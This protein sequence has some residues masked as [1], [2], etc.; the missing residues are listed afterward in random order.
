MCGFL[1]IHV[2]VPQVVSSTSLAS[3]AAGKLQGAPSP[4]ACLVHAL[5]RDRS[6]PGSLQLFT[7]NATATGTVS[8]PDRKITPL[9]A[10]PSLIYPDAQSE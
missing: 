9:G 7:I 2:A 1:K 4:T 10:A 8:R 6:W 5:P 3:V